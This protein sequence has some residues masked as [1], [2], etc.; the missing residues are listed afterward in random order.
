MGEEGEEGGGGEEEEEEEEDGGAEEAA[1]GSGPEPTPKKK[2]RRS[3][4]MDPTRV[5]SVLASH[6][7]IESYSY[8]PQHSLWCQ[9]RAAERWAAPSTNRK[10]RVTHADSWL[11][12]LTCRVRSS[13]S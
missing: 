11:L 8:D 1:D 2:K 7:A 12:K 4:S 3:S 6:H 10:R 9:V 5:T 13:L